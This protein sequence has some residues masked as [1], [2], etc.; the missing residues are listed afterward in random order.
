MTPQPRVAG[1]V[2]RATF[3]D[4]EIRALAAKGINAY[5]LSTDLPADT[6]SGSVWLKSIPA[7]RSLVNRVQATRLL[8]RPVAGLPVPNWADPRMWYRCGWVEHVAAQVVHEEKIDLVHSHFAWPNGQGGMIVRALT[9]RPLVAAFRGN[10]LLTSPEIG[11]GARHRP[12]FDRAVRGLLG[13]AERT[14]YFSQVMRNKGIEL[15][16]VPSRATVLHKG[17]DIDRFTV[18]EDRM[19]LRAELGFGTKPMIMTVAGLIA[20]KGVEDILAALARLRHDLDFTFVIVGDGPQRANLAE[21]SDRLG[22][23][24][25]TVFTGRLDRQTIPRYFA[26][27]DVFVLASL[28]EAAGNVV[29]EAMSAGRPVVCTDSGGPGEFVKDGQTG[30]VVPV[31]DTAAIAARVERL[32]RDTTLCEELGAAGRRRA[33]G[34]YSYDRMTADIIAIY[35]EVLSEQ[36]RKLMAAC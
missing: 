6:Q 25:R 8:V 19:A 10:D 26:A 24:D 3:M 17:V 36:S 27:C 28:V 20:R 23:G 18:S 35:R 33:V 5:I 29:L 30:F 12:A 9:G 7:R 1:R 2:T 4:E 21:L 32:V 13:A 34:E 11:Y 15:G 14:L 31:G 16:A 22:L